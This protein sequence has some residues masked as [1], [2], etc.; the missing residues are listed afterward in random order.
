M[1]GGMTINHGHC[2]RCGFA[3]VSQAAGAGLVLTA[4]FTR[5]VRL[6]V[7]PPLFAATVRLNARAAACDSFFSRVHFALTQVSLTF[8]F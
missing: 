1:E 8:S 6:A 4:N 5:Y 7:L 3:P 2:R